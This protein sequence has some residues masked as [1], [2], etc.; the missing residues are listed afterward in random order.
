M[1]KRD[2]NLLRYNS[3]PTD[4]HREKMSRDTPL[5]NIQADDIRFPGP[6]MNFSEETFLELKSLEKSINN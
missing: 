5:I 1:N 6:P 4:K 3:G 2:L